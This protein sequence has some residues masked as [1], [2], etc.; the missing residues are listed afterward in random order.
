MQN[1]R[2]DGC[3]LDCEQWKATYIKCITYFHI[4]V[5]MRENVPT[6]QINE[7]LQTL[8]ISDEPF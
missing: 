8:F 4:N 5:I 6:P 7:H 1:R 2:S 3:K